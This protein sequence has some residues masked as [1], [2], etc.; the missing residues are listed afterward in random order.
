MQKRGG[1]ERVIDKRSRLI[2]EAHGITE[3]R[4]NCA[5]AEIKYLLYMELNKEGT[6]IIY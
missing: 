1:K 5:R 4:T 3:V 6:C 2:K